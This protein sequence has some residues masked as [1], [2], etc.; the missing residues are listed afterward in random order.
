M[1]DCKLSLDSVLDVINLLI[2]S[3]LIKGNSCRIYTVFIHEHSVELLLH[4]KIMSVSAVLVICKVTVFV[5]V[6]GPPIS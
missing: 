6:L 3:F 1:S 5:N 2:E 4:L